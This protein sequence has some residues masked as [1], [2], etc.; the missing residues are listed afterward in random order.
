MQITKSRKPAQFVWAPGPSIAGAIAEPGSAPY[1]PA[2]M[3]DF[4]IIGGGIVGLASALALLERRPG[5]ELVLLEKESGVARHQ[6]GHNSGVIHSG[7]YY[8]PGSLKAQLCKAGAAATVAFAREHG[9]AHEI[10]GKLIVASDAL[11][12]ARLADLQARAEINGIVCE[13]IDAAELAR[14]EPMI[15]GLGALWI[16]STGIVDYP[17]LCLAMA[18]RIIALGGRIETRAAVTKIR[19]EP[20]G[21]T[22]SVGERSWRARQLVA[23][24][25]LQA[26]RVARLGGIDT[27]FRIVPFR[28]EYYRLPPEK[29]QIAKALIYPVPDPALPFLGVHLTRTVDGG[30]TVGPNA[31]LGLAREGYEKGAI[32]K[33]DAADI[34]AFPGFWRLARTQWR[35]GLSELRGSLS[36]RAYLARCRKYYPSLE[37]A[38][39]RPEPAGIRAQA[40][41]NDGTLVHDFLIRETARSVHVCNAPS[42]AATSALPIGAMIADN[43]LAQ[44]A[45]IN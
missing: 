21:V 24:A 44:L 42:P 7:I 27:D 37:L 9:V 10:C 1:R 3:D 40:V 36:R 32:D 2:A 26:D 35:S 33:A 13:A 23:C 19:E 28:G 29:S 30:M 5:A 4:C 12:L 43:V 17:A 39:L 16:P 14:R 20:D 34:L 45:N 8:T 11:E 18:A 6:T 41:L 31:V 38:D 25:G 22:V 15:A